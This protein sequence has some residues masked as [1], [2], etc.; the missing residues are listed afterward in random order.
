MGDRPLSDLTKTI[1]ARRTDKTLGDPAAPLDPAG[2]SRE[3]L[4]ALLETAGFAPVHYAAVAAHRQ[5]AL[6]SIVPYLVYKLDAGG[7]RR[8]LSQLKAS[9][10]EAGKILN[11]LAA[12]EALCLVTWLPEEG[13]KGEGDAFA[14]TLINMENIAAAS[15]VVQ[16]LLLLATE[17][18]LRSYWSSGGVLRGPELF[19][20]LEIPAAEI[21]LGA[22][23]LF[24]ADV[25]GSDVL[26]GKLREKRGELDDWSAW[27]DVK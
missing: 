11:M 4:D 27:R 3:A 16:N 25:G 14:G 23:Y 13:G 18:G 26:P 5:G 9:S 22:V 10:I 7:C 24:P 21:L 8:L 6:S 17:A 2:L 1:R 19:D 15:A 12:A 20:W